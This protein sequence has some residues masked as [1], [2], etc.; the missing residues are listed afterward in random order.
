MIVIRDLKT[1]CFNFDYRDE[2]DNISHN[3][4]DYKSFEYKTKII[5]KT[6]QRPA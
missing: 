1:F 4:S 5:G 2:T 3:V 6:P